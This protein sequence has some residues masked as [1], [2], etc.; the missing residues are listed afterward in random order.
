MV[1]MKTDA[2][3]TISAI[4][5]RIS[6]GRGSLGIGDSLRGRGNRAPVTRYIGCPPMVGNPGLAQSEQGIRAEAISAR[7]TRARSYSC[8][9]KYRHNVAAIRSRPVHGEQTRTESGV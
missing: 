9:L 2:Q 6:P 5:S 3:T 4:Y 1:T 7:V 8:P